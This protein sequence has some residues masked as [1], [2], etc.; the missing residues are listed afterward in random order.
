MG[1]LGKIDVHQH[2]L[3]EPYV[4]ALAEIGV[5]GAGGVAFPEWRP[6]AALEM[7]DAQNIETGLLSISSPGVHFGDDAA[8]ASLA[9]ASGLRPPHGRYFRWR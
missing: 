3:P 6:Q 9:R 7:M 2:V 8:A 4:D 1:Q 5:H